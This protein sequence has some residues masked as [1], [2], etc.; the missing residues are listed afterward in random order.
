VFV[1][2][3][4]DKCP[5][6]RHE[7][8]WEQ[9][10]AGEDYSAARRPHGED[11][12]RYGERNHDGGRHPDPE[13]SQVESTQTLNGPSDSV[14]RATVA[15]KTGSLASHRET[16]PNASVSTAAGMIH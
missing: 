8:D 7:K 14:E 5:G 13:V 12:C 6:Q 2:T 3:R 16:Y 15:I 11:E 10:H 1:G 9:S 4:R